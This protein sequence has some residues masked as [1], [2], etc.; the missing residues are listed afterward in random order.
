MLNNTTLG[1]ETSMSRCTEDWE[2]M[3]TCF[4]DGHFSGLTGTM[5]NDKV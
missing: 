4:G 2:H 1:R 5:L 3:G